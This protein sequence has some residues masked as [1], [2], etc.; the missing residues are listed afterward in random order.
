MLDAFI[1]EE[2]KRREKER[3][4][5]EQERPRIDLPQVDPEAAAE[6]ERER[7]APRKEQGS[8]RGVVRLPLR[9]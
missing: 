4:D 3:R 9:S 1:I 5:R 8:S 7:K 2:L 6:H